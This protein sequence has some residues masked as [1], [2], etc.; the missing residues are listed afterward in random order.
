MRF[1]V[2]IECFFV[3]LQ[4]WMIF[5]TVLLFLMYHTALSMSIIRN[6]KEK[7]KSTFHYLEY[8]LEEMLNGFTLFCYLFQTVSTHNTHVPRMISIQCP[9]P[10]VLHNL[11]W[12][13]YKGIK[14]AV[15]IG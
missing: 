11:S 9:S 3:I 5:L 7:D 13:A 1:S 15:L 12:L 2:L 14:E 10:Q 4:L 6:F 8:F